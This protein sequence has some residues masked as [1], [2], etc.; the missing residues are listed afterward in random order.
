MD[1]GISDC[2]DLDK[3]DVPSR[4]EAAHQTIEQIFEGC[5]TDKLRNTFQEKLK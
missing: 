5:I 4:I 3:N 2:Q 1:Y